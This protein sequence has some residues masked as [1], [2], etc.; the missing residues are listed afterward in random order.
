MNPERPAGRAALLIL[1]SIG[2]YAL[3][4]GIAA[5][6]GVLIWFEL[7]VL[8]IMDLLTVFVFFAALAVLWSV[9][10]RFSRFTPPGPQLSP[11]EH[12]DLFALV[13]RLAAEARVPVPEQVFLTMEANAGVSELGF[14]GFRRK[15]LLVGLPLLEVLSVAQLQA[16]LAHEFGHFR[17]GDAALG[18]IAYRTRR[19]IERTIAQLARSGS[20]VANVF[21]AY[22]RFYLRVT[23]A[24]S[25]AQETAADLF[26]ARIAGSEHAVKALQSVAML[27]GV[28]PAFWAE[29]VTPVLRAGFRPALLELFGRYARAEAV[30]AR[31]AE[32]LRRKMSIS[33]AHPFDSHPVLKDRI[34]AIEALE[35][36]A[37]ENGRDGLAISLLDRERAEE[38]MLRH[39]LG[40]AWLERLDTA[41]WN[42]LEAAYVTIWRADLRRVETALRGIAFGSPPA[43]WGSLIMFAGQLAI[44]LDLEIDD[45]DGKALAGAMFG[46]A[47]SLVLH[48]RGWTIRKAPGDGVWL[49][50]GGIDIEPFQVLRRLSSVELD[51]AE[52][53]ALCERIGIA[54]VELTAAL[55]APARRGVALA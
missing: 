46:E 54:G 5:L 27:D 45:E 2:Y 49:S 12:P 33:L 14:P 29:E 15:L 22:G 20:R 9:I 1:L 17:G 26:A 11:A 53:V 52:W 36:R 40:A 39:V 10:P 4:L 37:G 34:A 51:L 28:V 30:H 3:A 8:H 13:E 42:D 48:G 16:V 50:S 25:R 24:L 38:L 18:A 19:R 43:G 44:C 23:R 47:L 32:D 41:P 55:D 31:M 6:A 7:G 35:C 21:L